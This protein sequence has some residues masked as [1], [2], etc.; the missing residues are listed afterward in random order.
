MTQTKKVS[1][2]SCAT[3]AGKLLCKID[4]EN[5]RFSKRCLLC[6]SHV[7]WNFWRCSFSWENEGLLMSEKITHDR[8]VLFLWGYYFS[9]LTRVRRKLLMVRAAWQR[10][11]YSSSSREMNW[12]AWWGPWAAAAAPAGPAVLE[13]AERCFSSRTFISKTYSRAC[14][15]KR[16]YS[17]YGSFSQS[18]KREIKAIHLNKEQKLWL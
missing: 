13:P 4:S 10:A 14:C 5:T 15:S 2:F 7:T 16:W 17:W 9:T 8:G 6:S 11:L 3:S 1:Y 18:L 12:W